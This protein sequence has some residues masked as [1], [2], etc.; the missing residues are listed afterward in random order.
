MRFGADGKL[1]LAENGAGQVDAIT[2][3][4]DNAEVM[5]LKAASTSPLQ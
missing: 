1:Y 4:G 5:V 2:I 3:N